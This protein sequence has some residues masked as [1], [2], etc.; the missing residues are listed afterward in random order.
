MNRFNVAFAVAIAC[1]QAGVFGE[2]GTEKAYA[3]DQG[4]LVI[5]EPGRQ[6]GAAKVAD[7]STAG[8][9]EDW[10]LKPLGAPG[11][12]SVP[13][14]T[15]AKKPAYRKPRAFAPG[16]RFW[17]KDAKG[18]V[19]SANA[20]MRELA[21][22]LAW[23]LSQMCGA[24]VACRDTVPGGDAPV[25]VVGGAAEGEVRPGESV[26]HA[27][28]RR[29]DVT[30]QGAGVAYAVTYLLEAMG[31]RYLW[32]GP[33]GKIVPKRA[34]IILPD[35]AWRY[36]PALKQRRMRDYDAFERYSPKLGKALGE[37]WGID[38]AR[39]MAALISNRYD[40]AGNRDFF[41]WHGVN[42]RSDLPG[43]WNAAHNFMD[44]WQKHG[45]QH[46]DWFALQ[47]NGSRRQDLGNLTDRNT[48]CL[49]NEGLREQIAHDAIEA[50][51]ANRNLSA[52]S[53][54]LPDGGYM[55]Q[56]MCRRCRELDP[57]NARPEK[58]QAARP[59]PFEADYV[60]LT[61]RVL[62]FCNAIAAR[63]TREIP[64]AKFGFTIYSVYGKPP[65]KVR[66]HP[67]LVLW[68]AIGSVVTE[69]G[70]AAAH[71]SLASWSG[72]GNGLVWRP[73]TFMQF[74]VNAPQNFARFV[75]EDLE[76]FK[77]NNLIG[78]DFDCVNHQFATRGLM[79]YLTAK[80]HRNPDEI[81][82]DDIV[83]DYCKAGFGAAAADVRMYFDALER[84]TDRATQLGKG[85]ESFVEAFDPPLLAAILTKANRAVKD[86]AMARK[87][88]DYLRLGL[89][90]GT[91]EKKLG[92]A[93]AVKDR[94]A[95]L[96]I[97][98]EYKTFM[99]ACAYSE[100]FAVNP[101]FV[102]SFWRRY[103]MRNPRF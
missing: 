36:V 38:G 56:C 43:T 59:T 78:T 77:R 19:V 79:W 84:M 69:E 48:L 20:G 102:C 32:P 7:A 1:C 9:E 29:M 34:E 81:G 26:I 2:Q 60:C 71:K 27:Q 28:G 64:S 52:Y 98:A 75:F 5:F 23:H 37:A 58:F 96:R 17:G 31:C 13:D 87:R 82:Y 65:V 54:G 16:I 66:P 83:D 80:A 100:P 45:A 89:A 25:I 6:G 57:V 41:R 42:D 55:A 39:F 15:F 73:N 63:V 99:Q 46:P 11:T 10:G 88:I 74:G 18:C 50:F 97:Q 94:E 103:Q 47:R 90:A 40:R 86:D 22:E 76:T 95:I 85:I 53:L 8:G 72:F 35:L 62:D 92:C 61:D 21:Q 51:R 12:L 14:A 67:A 4:R 44:F 33:L 91:F 93:W 68:S 3:D 24:E 49:S 30:G 101:I 70:R